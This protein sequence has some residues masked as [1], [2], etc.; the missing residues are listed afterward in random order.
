[1]HPRFPGPLLPQWEG[2]VNT[3]SFAWSLLAEEFDEAYWYE[4]E[5]ITRVMR[6]NIFDGLVFNRP[7]RFKEGA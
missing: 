6:D 7:P 3:L 5:Q 1:M 4:F 2:V